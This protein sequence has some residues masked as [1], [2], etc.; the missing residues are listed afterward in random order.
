MHSFR[1]MNGG[2][3]E[4]QAC[5]TNPKTTSGQGLRYSPASEGRASPSNRILHFVWAFH[6]D[7]SGIKFL[8]RY[9][10]PSHEHVRLRKENNKLLSKNN[11]SFRP[12]TSEPAD[13]SKF[14]PQ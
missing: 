6:I 4:E 14:L 11:T 7:M 1:L 8:R 2:E 12:R 5:P 10:Y 9:P 13:P 3:A